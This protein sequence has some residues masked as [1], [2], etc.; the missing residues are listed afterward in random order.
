MLSRSKSCLYLIFL[1][2]QVNF[3]KN[4]KIFPIL[5][6]SVKYPDMKIFFDEI[7]DLAYM[8]TIFESVTNHELFML[9]Q[10]FGFISSVIVNGRIIGCVSPRVRRSSLP[11]G[12]PNQEMMF[13][14]CC[15][16]Y[17]FTYVTYFNKAPIPT[18][19]QFFFRYGVIQQHHYI[20]SPHL[21]PIR[22]V[23]CKRNYGPNCGHIAYGR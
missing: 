20:I 15:V 9:Y 8:A 5:I 16:Y 17:Y 22:F 13:V 3:L 11:A 1:L 14:L 7:I 12:L 19:L 2:L 18:P 21:L 23:Q 4:M 10:S 6:P